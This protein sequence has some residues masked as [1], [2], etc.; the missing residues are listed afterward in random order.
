MITKVALRDHFKVLTEQRDLIE[1]EFILEL[2]KGLE[3]I[4]HKKATLFEKLMQLTTQLLDAIN[5]LE[6]FTGKAGAQGV[7]NFLL[8]IMKTASFCFYAQRAI[9]ELP[10]APTFNEKLWRNFNKDLATYYSSFAS[11]LHLNTKSELYLGTSF[12][13]MFEE[14]T[15]TAISNRAELMIR[16]IATLDAFKLFIQNTTNYSFKLQCVVYLLLLESSDFAMPIL[17]YTIA[18]S[19]NEDYR[20]KL[21]EPYDKNPQSPDNL[22]YYHFGHCNVSFHQLYPMIIKLRS[23]SQNAFKR[24]ANTEAI[25]DVKKA[26]LFFQELKK[27]LREKTLSNGLTT[28]INLFENNNNLNAY[29]FNKILQTKD[30]L[31]HVLTLCKRCLVMVD[32][33]LIHCLLATKNNSETWN[34]H[35]DALILKR[36]SLLKLIAFEKLSKQLN[37]DTDFSFVSNL[38][39][40]VTQLNLQIGSL[41]KEKATSESR[42]NELFAAQSRKE[43]E[44]AAQKKRLKETIIRDAYKQ[45]KISSAATSNKEETKETRS[46]ENKVN[47]FD[48]KTQA[49]FEHFIN[50]NLKQALKIYEQLLNHAK[51]YSPEQIANLHVCIGDIYRELSNRNSAAS[52]Q[53]TSLQTALAHY[54]AALEAADLGLLNPS[55]SDVKSSLEVISEIAKSLQ[56]EVAKMTLN[57][58]HASD[59]DGTSTRKTKALELIPTPLLIKT[60]LEL[61]SFFQK[62]KTTLEATGYHLL[63]TGGFVRDHLLGVCAFDIDA[64]VFSTRPDFDRTLQSVFQTLKKI[65][66]NCQLRGKKYPIIFLQNQEIIIELSRLRINPTCPYNLNE[67]EFTHFLFEDARNRDTTDNALYYAPNEKLI[68]DFFGGVNDIKQN[69]LNL[70]K[71]PNVSFAEDPS[72]IFRVLRSI[73]RRSM[74]KRDLE[75]SQQIIDAMQLG[76]DQLRQLDRNRCYA[77]ITKMLFRGNALATWQFLIQYDLAPLFFLLPNTAEATFKHKLMITY[78][79]VNLDSRI[80]Q[81][82]DFNKALVFAIL[83]WGKFSQELEL[84]KQPNKPLGL[85]QV[86]LLASKILEGP[87]LLFKIPEHLV[88]KIKTIWYVHLHQGR[89]V[90]FDRLDFKLKDFSRACVL[91]KL[92]TKVL[93]QTPNEKLKAQDCKSS[94]FK[95]HN[96]E[97]LFK[98]MVSSYNLKHTY[99]NKTHFLTLGD[100][101]IASASAQLG[102][103][104]KVK[105]NIQMLLGKSGIEYELAPNQLSLHTDWADK[106]RAIDNLMM[107]LFD[108]SNGPTLI[109][110]YKKASNQ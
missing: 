36:K 49:A 90:A 80:N 11:Q 28:F 19:L 64:V 70:I 33:I 12:I 13:L 93:N 72:R 101:L 77:E 62:I 110:I 22:V 41:E 7:A 52:D 55:S 44:A 5:H 45:A 50:G 30:L 68:V 16:F 103:L 53:G 10:S 82:R 34:L 83:L 71:S 54:Q 81:Q 87:Q 69:K 66:P 108:F 20:K 99:K 86:V 75:Y 51:N 96:M 31:N 42:Y 67:P 29:T 35:F 106:K 40:Q 59:D 48:F 85:N 91:T 24:S 3:G 100:E 9:K 23:E 60:A 95:S 6:S 78:L 104:K 4:R 84:L 61:P 107:K 43:A 47:T 46:R 65:Y 73:V 8:E 56:Q 17:G 14:L 94:F 105:F 58:H 63:I 102:A 21:R 39:Q 27:I 98:E 79:L 109:P 25:L 57:K 88:M 26:E 18:P 97:D 38:E 32:D 1:R 37:Q 2:Q 92:E 89:L 76:K 15:E 74:E